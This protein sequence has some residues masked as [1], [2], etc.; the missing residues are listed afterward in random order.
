M[1]VQRNVHDL[2]DRVHDDLVQDNRI[3]HLNYLLAKVV[4]E[5]VGHHIRE[6]RQHLID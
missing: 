6:N 3:S 1:D 5:L 4:S 2:V